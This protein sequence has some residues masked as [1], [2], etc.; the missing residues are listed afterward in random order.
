[1]TRIWHRLVPACAAAVLLAAGC[2]TTDTFSQLTGHRWLKTELNTYDVIII[3]VDGTSYIEKPG[4]P[5]MIDPGPRAIVVQGLPTAGF[6]YGQQRTL[7]LDVQPCTRYWLEAKKT[8]SLEQDF[9]ARVNYSE[10]IAGCG[11]KKQ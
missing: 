9:E 7:K 10:P 3:S 11:V 4:I 5:V 1:M 6:A 8:N 2:A